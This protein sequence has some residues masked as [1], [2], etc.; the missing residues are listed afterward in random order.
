MATDAVA[1]AGKHG[2]HEQNQ[3]LARAVT[4]RVGVRGARQFQNCRS[5]V[6]EEEGRR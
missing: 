4:D 6:R 3:T 1:Y 2:G 5:K